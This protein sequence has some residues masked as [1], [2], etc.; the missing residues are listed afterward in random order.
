MRTRLFLSALTCLF[1]LGLASCN[2]DSSLVNDPKVGDVYQIEWK[3]FHGHEYAY[4]LVKVKAIE[5]DKLTL[6]P[7]RMYYHE[8]VYCLATGDAFSTK[9]AYT[10]SK[11]EIKKIFDQGG[12]VDVFRLYESSCLGNEQ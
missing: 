11:A 6:M 2:T 10:S 1:T 4:Q 7:N 8:K 3:N 5:G 9:N 12:I